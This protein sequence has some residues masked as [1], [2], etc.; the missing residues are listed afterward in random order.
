MREIVSFAVAVV[1]AFICLIYVQDHRPQ[2]PFGGLPHSASTTTTTIP[3]RASNRQL[4]ADGG[5]MI[6]AVQAQDGSHPVIYVSQEDIR[7]EFTAPDNEGTLI[8]ILH[9]GTMY[10]NNPPSPNWISWSIK[11]KESSVGKLTGLYDMTIDREEITRQLDLMSCERA[12][13]DKTL[14]TP[15]K[16]ANITQVINPEGTSDLCQI[17]DYA[18]T[19]AEAASCKA[20]CAN[21]G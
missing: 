17:C 6:C 20:E 2:Q 16:D 4:L 5:D 3:P 12:T 14:F 21:G 8:E 11:D 18:P 10:V 9:N 7:V 13:L 19:P 1:L 15:P